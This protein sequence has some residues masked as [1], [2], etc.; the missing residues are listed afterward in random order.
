MS[1]LVVARDGNVHIAQRVC[2]AQTGGRQVNIRSFCEWSALG[3]VTTR[4]LGSQKAAWMLL[5][6][7][8]GVKRPA[9]GVA[10]VAAANFST[11]CWPVFRDNMTL[12]SAGFSIAT[13][14]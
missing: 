14:A 6:K 2:A 11:A 8:L 7:V 1:S 4:S 5:V 3:S 9:I 10:P 13:M 12:T